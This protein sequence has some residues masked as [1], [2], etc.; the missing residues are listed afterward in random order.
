MK[1]EHVHTELPLHHRNITPSLPRPNKKNAARTVPTAR[2]LESKEVTVQRFNQAT[3]PS[4]GICEVKK[5][6]R[7]KS[8]HRTPEVSRGKNGDSD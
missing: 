3:S 6:T 2:P 4:G 5:G 8:P 7:E 1:R